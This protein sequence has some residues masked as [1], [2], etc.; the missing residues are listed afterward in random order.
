MN[1]APDAA[2]LGHRYFF[3]L[4]PDAET[5]RRTAIFA[6]TELGAQGLLAPD[7]LHVTLALTPDRTMEAADLV[8]A[9]RRAGDAVRAAPFDLLL[10]R[11][12]IGSRTAALRPAGK[13]PPLQA[14]QAAIA[15][16][17]RKEGIAMRPDWHFSPHQTLRYR[18]SA[19]TGT[20]AVTGFRW[21][22]TDFVLVH[23]LIGLTRHETI[24]RWRLRAEPEPQGRLL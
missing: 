20:R 4:K 10:D 19:T 8:D 2:L 15:Q 22:V 7:R 12:S 11:L 6:E 13:V 17:M 14:L 1:H 9:L 23:S 24:G 18:K 3:A 21:H 16:S 5:A